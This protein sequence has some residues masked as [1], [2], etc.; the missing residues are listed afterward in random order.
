[1]QHVTR[2]CGEDMLLYFAER[3]YTGYGGLMVTNSTIYGTLVSTLLA[4]VQSKGEY[5]GVNHFCGGEDC[6]LQCIDGETSHQG[7]EDRPSL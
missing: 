5:I 1:M 2:R 7:R 3:V 4:D 6:N